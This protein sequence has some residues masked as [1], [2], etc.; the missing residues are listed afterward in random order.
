MQGRPI[1]IAKVVW[2]FH[3]SNLLKNLVSLAGKISAKMTRFTG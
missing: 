2:F 3:V 1:G